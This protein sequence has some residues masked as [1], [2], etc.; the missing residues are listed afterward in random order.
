MRKFDGGN[1]PYRELHAQFAQRMK[2]IGEKYG[3]LE[4][5]NHGIK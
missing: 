5:K 1:K 4:E 3:L 2:A